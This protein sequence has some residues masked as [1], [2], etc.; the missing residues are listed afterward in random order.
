MI[1]PLSLAPPDPRHLPLLLGPGLW[2]S[3]APGAVASWPDLPPDLSDMV[4][5]SSPSLSPSSPPLA[6]AAAYWEKQQ[7]INSH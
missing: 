5:D 1:T 6:K 7:A 2:A 3:V 4:S